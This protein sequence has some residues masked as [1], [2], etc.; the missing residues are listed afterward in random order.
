MSP[1]SRELM[2]SLVSCGNLDLQDQWARKRLLKL[3]STS[4]G[5]RYHHEKCMELVYVRGARH[6]SKSDVSLHPSTSRKLNESN[7]AG[8]VDAGVCIGE[9]TVSKVRI[10]VPASLR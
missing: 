4:D 6:G 10:L 5:S 9:A 3:S 7:G 1:K 2:G 8:M